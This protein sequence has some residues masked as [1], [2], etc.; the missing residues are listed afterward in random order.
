M[1]RLSLIL[2]SILALGVSFAAPGHARSGPSAGVSVSN[3][4]TFDDERVDGSSILVKTRTDVGMTL[5]VR[6]LAPGEA[7]TAWWVAFNNPARC[8]VKCRCGEVDFEN[9]NVDIGVLWATGR[10]TD[11][12]GQAAFAAS[13]EFGTLPD[14][15]D[16]VP[17]APSFASPIHQKAEIHIIVRSHGLASGDP[18]ELEDQLTM[19]Q[20]GFGTD[21]HFAVHPS[22]QCRK[23]RR[24]N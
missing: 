7:Y 10:V 5:N 16:Q 23:A 12:Y 13:S 9:P 14:G 17:F 2:V 15:D 11:A 8:T 1:A 19:F 3:V 6:G 24:R 18:D 21:T 20:D 4:Y 22:S